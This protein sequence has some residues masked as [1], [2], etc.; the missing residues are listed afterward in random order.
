MTFVVDAGMV[1]LSLE[2][3]LEVPRVSPYVNDENEERR[4]RTQARK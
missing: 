4:S 1:D 2:R 3:D